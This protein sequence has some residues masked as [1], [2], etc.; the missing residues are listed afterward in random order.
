MKIKRIAVELKVG[1]M[2]M[3]N[4]Q[5]ADPLNEYAKALKQVTAKKKKTDEDHLEMA[6]REFQG[7][8]YYDEKLGPYVPSSWIFK[9]LVEGARKRKNGKEVGGYVTIEE[10]KIPIQYDGPRT[11]EKLFAD[12]RFT[13]R[14]C[15]KVGTA[16]V[17]RTRPRFEDC[18]LAFTI[19][20]YEGGPNVDVI[21]Q[22][23]DAAT[24]AVGIGDGRPGSPKGAAA[25]GVGTFTIEKFEAETG[26]APSRN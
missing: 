24:L 8:L 12:P 11:R 17:M 21:E 16:K 4:Q 23:L 3:H 19:V 1:Q 7:G 14:R 2:M 20:V 25:P 15:V 5:L 10:L 13:D 9:M 26:V 22:A 6:R 18:T